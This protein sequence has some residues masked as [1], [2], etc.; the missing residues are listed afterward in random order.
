MPN[1]IHKICALLL[2]PLLLAPAGGAYAQVWHPERDNGI[3]NVRSESSS[4]LSL[5]YNPTESWNAAT[6]SWLYSKGDFHRAD[7]P[8]GK[9]EL[10]LSVEELGKLGA[11]RTSGSLRYRNTRDIDRNWNSLIGNDPDNPYVICDTLADNSTTERF[12]INGVLSWEFSD[13]WTAAG[14]IGLTTATLTDNK[15]PRPKNDI[16]R[17]P[18][19]L[20]L[21][22]RLSGGWSA[23]IFG[24]A[25][26][27]FSKFSN[28]LEYGQKTYRYYKMKG[29]G[30]FFAFSSSESSSAPREY[31]GL[32]YSAGANAA[33]VRDNVEL[34]TEVA[35]T[36]GY[37]NARDGGS[38][39][40]WKAGD[41][42]YNR[43]SL[44][45]RVDL[46]GELRQSVSL[47]AGIKLTEG[48]WYDQKVRI[49]TEH[50]N[51]AYYE[52]MSRYKNNNSMRLIAKALYRIGRDMSWNAGLGL[53]FHSENNT[54][55]ADGSP[56]RQSWSQI[57]INADG[58][59]TLSIG[60]NILDISAGAG[61]IL[62][63]GKAVYATGSTAA[64]KDDI[65]KRF[66]DPTFAYETS[67]KLSGLV[68]ADWVFAPIKKLRPGLFVKGTILKQMG[69]APKYPSLEGTSFCSLT[70]GAVITF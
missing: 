37:E 43:I 34:F 57:G 25:E 5:R 68:R 8:A 36:G 21:E 4:P 24:G 1:K 35:Y 45:G 2:L 15:D 70:A 60:R 66:V 10:D 62:P 56:C 26:L 63:I 32:S 11:F 48:F 33:M 13:N 65:T 23:G 49:D 64:A 6:A 29:M 30:D 50:G 12:D 3:K 14:K 69:S 27:F 20:G 41:Y 61:Y 38:A 42:N 55:Y 58:W 7:R 19:V 44:Q 31:S 18:L 67:G 22:R 9:S 17:I 46:R 53:D 39:Y 59:K 47:N 40:E 54:H 52:I 28:Y 16:S 51:L